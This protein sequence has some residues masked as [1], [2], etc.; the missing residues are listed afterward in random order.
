MS[1]DDVKAYVGELREELK[2]LDYELGEANTV[3]Y[4]LKKRIQ[5]DDK[6]K[7]K[8][9]HPAKKAAKKK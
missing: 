6:A 8:P 4:R 3:I 7:A 1:V 5:E 2:K 9:K